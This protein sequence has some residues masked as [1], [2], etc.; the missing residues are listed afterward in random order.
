MSVGQPVATLTYGGFSEYAVQKV[1]HSVPVSQ[2][3]PEAV[4]MLTSG[5]TASVALQEVCVFQALSICECD[6]S[7]SF[8]LQQNKNEDSPPSRYAFV[9]L[10]TD[11]FGRLGTPAMALLNKLAARAS[12]GGDVFKGGSVVNALRELYQVVKG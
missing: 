3:T 9:L 1:A 8:V 5:L 11:T 2:A 7:R 4:A 10:S 12:A 6:P